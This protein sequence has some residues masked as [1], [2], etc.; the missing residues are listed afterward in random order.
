MNAAFLFDKGNTSDEHLQGT[1]SFYNI[2]EH[3]G[4]K[5]L[6]FGEGRG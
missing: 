3:K 2:E 6:R 5:W 4:D 1:L